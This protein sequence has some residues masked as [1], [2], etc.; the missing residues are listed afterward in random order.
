MSFL[1]LRTFY[2]LRAFAAPDTSGRNIEWY[3]ESYT[4]PVLGG[5]QLIFDR[6]RRCI[7]SLNSFARKQRWG[8]D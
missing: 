3:C 5:R 7:V 1:L 8:H 6:Y 2:F 4:A